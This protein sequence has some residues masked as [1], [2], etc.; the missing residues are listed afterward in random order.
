MS[1]NEYK[2]SDD[3][4][5]TYLKE[6]FSTITENSFVQ[7]SYLAWDIMCCNMPLNIIQNDSG[8]MYLR[9]FDIINPYYATGIR[10]F[11]M[12]QIELALINEE[13]KIKVTLLPLAVND[14][15]AN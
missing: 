2:I 5:I 10:R 7:L 11:H 14:Y 12:I 15:P 9:G 1:E 3:K 13:Y 8:D 6:K 4:I